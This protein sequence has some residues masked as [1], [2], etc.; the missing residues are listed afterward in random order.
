MPDEDAPEDPESTR[1]WC[2]I[3]K[4]HTTKDKTSQELTTR[5]NVGAD[6]GLAD[7]MLTSP[8]GSLGSRASAA[9]IAQAGRRAQ[10]GLAVYHDLKSSGAGYSA[11][12]RHL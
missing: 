11:H 2:F 9:E 12:Y 5:I 6:P 4:T 10:D 8:C 3:K 7:A 1:Y